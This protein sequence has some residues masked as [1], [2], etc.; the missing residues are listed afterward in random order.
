VENGLLYGDDNKADLSGSIISTCISPGCPRK[1]KHK[2][3][4]SKEC[5][6]VA[7]VLLEKLC[8]RGGISV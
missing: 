2:T 8:R 3:S 4:S 7:K 1:K 5:D 6:D